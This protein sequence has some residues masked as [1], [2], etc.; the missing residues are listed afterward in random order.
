[1]YADTKKLADP[2][3]WTGP[4]LASNRLI[5]AGSHGFAMAISPYSGRIIGQVK[6]PSG[7]SVP[8]V[9]ADGIVYFLANDAELV[10]YR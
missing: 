9:V 2:I 8:P 4:V 5:V 6:L 10:A 1:R 3:I 7:V